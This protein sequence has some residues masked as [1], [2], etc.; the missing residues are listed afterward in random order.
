MAQVARSHCFQRKMRPV[1]GSKSF[2]VCL[3]V[4]N[5]TRKQLEQYPLRIGLSTLVSVNTTNR[6]GQVLANKVRSTPVAVSTA[7]EISLA[8]V[9]KLIDDIVKANAG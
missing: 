9:N 8:P 5:W 1:T 7:R 4:S 6:D 2:S 3:C